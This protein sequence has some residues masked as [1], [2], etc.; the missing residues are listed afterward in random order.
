MGST[1]AQRDGSVI[2]DGLNGFSDAGF[3]AEV[4]REFACEQAV[5]CHPHRVDI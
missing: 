2:E 5:S 1:L 3:P 4:K